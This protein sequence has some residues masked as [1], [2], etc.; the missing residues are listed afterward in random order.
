MR[1]LPEEEEEEE[2]EE[3]V[4]SDFLAEEVAEEESDAEVQTLV[5]GSFLTALTSTA[6]AAWTLGVAAA[7]APFALDE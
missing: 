6:A 5:A 4:C 7:E 3:W 1:P 2:E